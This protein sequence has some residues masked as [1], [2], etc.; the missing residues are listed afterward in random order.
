MGQ[1]S[2]IRVEPLALNHIENYTPSPINTN[3][4]IHEIDDESIAHEPTTSL[5]EVLAYILDE[6]ATN[7]QFDLV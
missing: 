2:S 6:W 3:C 7:F 4:L 1:K 5:I